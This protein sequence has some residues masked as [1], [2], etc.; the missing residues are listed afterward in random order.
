MPKKI[1][2]TFRPLKG[3]EVIDNDGYV[4]RQCLTEAEHRND[5]TTVLYDPDT[6]AFIRYMRIR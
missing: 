1:Q 2:K 6:F 4:W 5:N 3:N